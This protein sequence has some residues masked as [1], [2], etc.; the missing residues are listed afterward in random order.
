MNSGCWS[1]PFAKKLGAE[2]W[3]RPYP[4][5]LTLAAAGLRMSEQLEDNRFLW[6]V[7]P[8]RGLGAPPIISDLMYGAVL[9]KMFFFFSQVWLKNQRAQE[10]GFQMVFSVKCSFQHAFFFLFLIFNLYNFTIIWWLGFSGSIGG[11]A[12]AIILLTKG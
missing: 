5:A 7:N 10:V 8:P 12:L 2:G 6:E 4:G 9:G 1:C 11:K 3:D